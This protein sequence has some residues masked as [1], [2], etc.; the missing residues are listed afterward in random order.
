MIIV[1]MPVDNFSQPGAGLPG[2]WEEVGLF[3]LSVYVRERSSKAERLSALRSALRESHEGRV[4][5]HEQKTVDEFGKFLDWLR[6]H[7][8]TY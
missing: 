8:R 1:N 2:R 3:D 5:R 7:V 6:W 4:S